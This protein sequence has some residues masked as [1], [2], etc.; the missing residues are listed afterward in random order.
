M[1][2]LRL[3]VFVAALMLCFGVVVQAQS[4]LA[5]PAGK[6]PELTAEARIEAALDRKVSLDAK[7]M[8]FDQLINKLSDQVQVPIKIRKRVEDAGVQ[9]DQPITM[10]LQ[11]VKLRTY[12]S[13]VLDNLHVTYMVKNEVIAI[14]TREDARSPENLLTRTYPVK[15]LVE[16]RKELAGGE[17]ELD[18]SPLVE[19]V[20]CTLD[21]DG[22]GDVG[23]PGSVG[24]FPNAGALVV[25]S[26]REVHERIERLL[27]TLRKSKEL[28]KSPA[29]SAAAGGTSVAVPVALPLGTESE[30]ASGAKIE[31]AL[32]KTGSFVFGETPLKD[33]I[34]KMSGDSGIPIVLGKKIEEAGVSP[35]QFITI[36]VQKVSLRSFL[37]LLLDE[38]NLTFVTQ[39]ELVKITTIEDA[40]ADENLVIWVYPVQDLSEV[41][42]QAKSEEPAIDFAP[43]IERIVSSIDADA[44]GDRQCLLKE[45]ALTRT[46]V[47]AQR[48]EIHEKIADLLTQ[49]RKT[50]SAQGLDGA[51]EPMPKGTIPPPPTR[52]ATAPR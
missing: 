52:P 20:T 16:S 24:A 44:W 42:R 22:W 12:L 51:P 50:K 33:V 32:S 11:G 19:L 21:P 25:T 43:L 41:P 38:L 17:P 7:G 8:P 36:E 35:H 29:S 30:L 1:S 34:A 27:V 26:S 39:G 31:A 48:E 14:T 10:S 13:S 18:F 4:S 28:L 45:F 5:P 37:R 6:P 40:Q 3:C 23:G 15:D 49:L 46:L 9:L 47:I 2:G